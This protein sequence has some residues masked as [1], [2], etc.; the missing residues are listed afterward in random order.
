MKISFQEVLVNSAVQ[1]SAAE[2]E[3][4]AEGGKSYNGAIVFKQSNTKYEGT[5]D[6][7]ILLIEK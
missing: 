6:A 1:N 7:N 2:T 4:A 3:M 5:Y